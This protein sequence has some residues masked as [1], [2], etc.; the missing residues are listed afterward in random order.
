MAEPMAKDGKPVRGTPLHRLHLELTSNP[1]AET[2]HLHAGELRDVA[3]AV[4]K[5]KAAA[6]VIA[7][8]NGKEP[9]EKVRVKAEDVSALVD[10][11]LNGPPEP[12]AD[13]KAPA[14]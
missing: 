2:F 9:S 5:G 14:K 8:T 7:L 6:A 11:A 4:G 10:A 13:P 3:K 12:P 1:D